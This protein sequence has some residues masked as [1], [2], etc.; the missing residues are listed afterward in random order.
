MK[1]FEFRLARVLDLRRMEAEM[2]ANNLAR[3]EGEMEKLHDRLRELA[4]AYQH[5]V[6]IVSTDPLERAA[7][8]QYRVDSE[9]RKRAA[10]TRIRAQEQA[11]SAQRALYQVAK[12]RVEVLERVKKRQRGEWDRQF[13]KELDDMAL[14]SYLARWSPSP[15]R[16]PN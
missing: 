15:A 16:R 6:S 1:R 3:L 11:I 10:E 7:L 4:D 5:Q 9:S 13:Q 12:Q 8:G 2:E 14:D